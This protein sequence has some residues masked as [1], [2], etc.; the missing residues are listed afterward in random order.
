MLQG[1]S[2]LERHTFFTLTYAAASSAC[3][4]L[5]PVT[6]ALHMGLVINRKPTQGQLHSYMAERILRGVRSTTLETFV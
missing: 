5:A 2:V 3:N 6:R 4:D 1:L